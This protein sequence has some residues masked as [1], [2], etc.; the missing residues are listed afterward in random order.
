M[1][2]ATDTAE[3]QDDVPL[4]LAVLP[5]VTMVAAPLL[6][7]A[8]SDLAAVLTAFVGA[9]AGGWCFYRR[10]FST[11]PLTAWNVALMVWAGYDLL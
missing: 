8:G 9:A 3:R 1:D 10:V 2:P 7:F 5:A 6:V 11:L 4:A